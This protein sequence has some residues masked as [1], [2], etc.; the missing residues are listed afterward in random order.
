MKRHLVVWGSLCLVLATGCGMDLAPLGFQ[1]PATATIG[2]DITSQV[3][4]FVYNL[5]GDPVEAGDCTGIFWVYFVISED[6]EIGL[7]D[8]IINSVDF[9]D[10]PIGGRE[11]K[12]VLFDDEYERL[13]ILPEAPLGQAYIGVYVD[14]HGYCLEL[15][16]QNN[17]DA[18]PI[19]I[20]P[21]Q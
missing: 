15:D 14:A 17:A 8:F 19:E 21:V 3:S 4:V 10:F 2:Q 13:E 6:E 9:V 11:A 18:L 7:D 16:E 20:L 12:P 1:A 5:G